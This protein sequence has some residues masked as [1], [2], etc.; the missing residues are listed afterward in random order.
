MSNPTDSKLYTSIKI[1]VIKNNP[2]N[3][4]YRSGMIVKEYEKLYYLKHGMNSN[5]YSNVTKK[6]DG[7]T[8]WFLEKWRNQRGTIGY[9]TKGDIYRPTIRVNSS[10]PKTLQELSK[11]EIKST[12]IEKRKTN[13]VKKF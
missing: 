7:L 4:A 12:M 6:V 10:T 11:K 1:K 9:D 8:R 13:R 2:I 5:P 3:S